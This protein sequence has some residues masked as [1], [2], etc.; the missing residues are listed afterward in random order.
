M[1]PI[2]SPTADALRALLR[3]SL[4]DNQEIREH[5]LGL[6][7]VTARAAG[8]DWI[9]RVEAFNTL[10]RQ[11][12]G[13]IPDN[14][15]SLATAILFGLWTGTAGTTLTERREGAAA[16]L[17]VH[18]DHF[19]KHIEPRVLARL[20]QALDAD[21]A[22]MVATQIAPPQ[23]VPVAARPA[24]LPEDIFAWEAV[25]H[26]EHLSRLWSAGYALHAELLACARIASMDLGSCDHVD[27]AE[28]AL[29][30]YGQLQV[31][32]YA[33]RR[34]YGIRM[35]HG[36]IAP[37]HLV[38]IAGWSPP[39]TRQDIDLLCHHNPDAEGPRS[40][41]TDLIAEPDGQFVRDHWVAALLVRHPT[42]IT[43]GGAHS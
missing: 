40:F 39:L 43:T 17:S 20:A 5:L 9:D 16:A 25:E 23:L 36:G 34:A 41:L 21:S 31:A 14:R 3:R 22:R 8:S 38:G 1:T 19:R 29:W 12:I 27:A 37:E 28:A 2:K 11:L 18:P 30:R 10:L 6:P 26:E 13:R 32:I 24:P 4:P 42:A 33:Y 15:M 35:L 7:G